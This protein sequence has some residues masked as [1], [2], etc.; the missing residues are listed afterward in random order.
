MQEAFQS[1]RRL[2]LVSGSPPAWSDPWSRATRVD[3]VARDRY[4]FELVAAPG[5]PAPDLQLVYE[6]RLE[7]APALAPSPAQRRYVH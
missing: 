6:A 4:D 2:E 3:V 1:G 5:E 7:E